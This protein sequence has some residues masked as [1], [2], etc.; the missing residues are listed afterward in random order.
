GP[1]MTLRWILRRAGGEARR[2]KAALI[3]LGGAMAVTAAL[4]GAAMLGA[5]AGGALLPRLQQEVHVIAYLDDGL[6]TAERDRLVAALR[7]APGVERA[8]LVGPDEAL[9]RLRAAAVSLG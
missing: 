6:G 9:G 3:G 7:L 8:R 2:R 5:R 1:L 4:S